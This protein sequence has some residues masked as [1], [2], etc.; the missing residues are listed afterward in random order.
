MILTRLLLYSMSA[1][2]PFAGAGPNLQQLLERISSSSA[3]DF[4]KN[5]S[6]LITKLILQPREDAAELGHLCQ[7]I[8]ASVQQK[9]QA[10]DG[11]SSELMDLA[12][13]VVLISESKSA[14]GAEA[15]AALGCSLLSLVL[16]RC[17]QILKLESEEVKEPLQ[18]APESKVED[19]DQEEGDELKRAR[20]RRRKARQSDSSDSDAE[21]FLS[22]E[23]DDDLFSDEEETESSGSPS[24]DESDQDKQ[25][26]S[27]EASV[28]ALEL[29]PQVEQ[30][31]LPLLIVLTDWL[32]CDKQIVAVSA[33]SARSLWSQMASV[34]NGFQ[35]TKKVD[36]I[37]SLELQPL[38]EDWRVF[39]LPKRN[40]STFPSHQLLSEVFNLLLTCGNRSFGFFFGGQ[41]SRLDFRYCTAH[42]TAD[43]IRPLAGVRGFRNGFPAIGRN[44]RLPV[45]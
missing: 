8:I 45:E 29:D 9:L 15:A 26:A 33:H 39:G 35:R 27:A 21:E 11:I 3:D 5:L 4:L 36:N 37:N 44:V 43:P 14:N 28:V 19:D 10:E 24:A 25:P 32:R 30:V 22:E 7:L 40:F 6:R 17:Q 13:V 42:R 38:P 12:V 1:V 16:S 34:L 18:P 20:I 31:L 41:R 23:D 2:K